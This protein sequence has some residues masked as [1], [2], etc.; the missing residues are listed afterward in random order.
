MLSVWFKFYII[1]LV[2]LKSIKFKYNKIF[3]D[4]SLNINKGINLI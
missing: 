3:L 1:F 4:S 2:K